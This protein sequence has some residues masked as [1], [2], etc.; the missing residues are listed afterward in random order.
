M[1]SE[2]IGIITL[3]SKNKESN[4]T[5]IL[6]FSKQV[7]IGK[8]KRVAFALSYASFTTLLLIILLLARIT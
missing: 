3:Q 5:S 2:V 6:N 1:K 4:K 7:K 8:N